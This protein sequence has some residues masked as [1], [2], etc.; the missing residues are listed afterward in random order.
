MADVFKEK[1]KEIEA[2]IA[3]HEKAVAQAQ[4]AYRKDPTNADLR[5]RIQAAKQPLTALSIDRGFYL[6]AISEQAGGKSHMP[7]AT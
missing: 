2:E 3:K 4:E 7:P 5:G 1:L 6:R